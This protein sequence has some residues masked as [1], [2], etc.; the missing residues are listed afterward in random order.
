MRAG[1][2]AAGRQGGRWQVAGGRRQAAG[3]TR[4]RNCHDEFMRAPRFVE[5][6]LIRGVHV[7]PYHAI[8][9]CMF[10]TPHPARPQRRAPIADAPDV[11]PV[12]EVLNAFLPPEIVPSDSPL[13]N[14]G[15]ALFD[16]SSVVGLSSHGGIPGGVDGAEP[17]AGTDGVLAEVLSQPQPRY[18]SI[19]KHA[20]IIGYVDLEFVIDAS[21][22]VEPGSVRIVASTH[23]R[24]RGVHWR[25]SSVGCTVRRGSG[26]VRCGNSCSGG[27]RSRAGEAGT[28]KRSQ[29]EW[30]A[31]ATRLRV[32]APAGA[33]TSHT[34]RTPTNEDNPNH[35]G[36]EPWAS[37][38]GESPK[39]E[40]Q[41]CADDRAGKEELD[42]AERN[43]IC[44]FPL[45]DIIAAVA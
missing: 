26:G 1:G 16:A 19:L 8:E 35:E 24:S 28:M 33:R 39:D 13:M 10:E 14:T 7:P 23:G 25:R 36:Q 40:C 3:G 5:L 6:G 17:R 12:P 31:R 2:R 41:C 37:R 22:R 18:P 15:N 29:E 9:G 21:G 38:W 4:Y 20:G 32:R 30:W 11:P 42:A 34:R 44:L 27:C 43:G 45:R